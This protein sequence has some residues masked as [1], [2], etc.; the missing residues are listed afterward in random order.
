M[1]IQIAYESDSARFFYEP[2]LRNHNPRN[3]GFDLC[4]TEDFFL[5]PGESKLVSLGVILKAPEG[6]TFDIM[7]RSSTFMKYGLIQG[8]SYGI[9][10]QDYC[11]AGD[12]LK[13]PVFNTRVEIVVIPAG[14]RIAQAVLR[15]LNPITEVVEFTPEDKNR[16]GFGSTGA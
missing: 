14:T 8:N 15:K 1:E 12:V 11:G 5:E 10:D 13:M 16:G 9:I 6:Y 7:P 4:V 3:T 2:L